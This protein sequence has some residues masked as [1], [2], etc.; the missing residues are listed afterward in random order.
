MHLPASIAKAEE[1][2]SSILTLSADPERLE[3]GVLIPSNS[4]TKTI[5]ITNEG[6]EKTSFTLSIVGYYQTSELDP[7]HT[8]ISEWLTFTGATE[9]TLAPQAST[10]ISLRVK[11][12]KDASAGG[13]YA[14]LLAGNPNSETI[15]LSTIS[16]IV[17]GSDLTYGG[18][19]SDHQ[20]QGFSFSPSINS[21]A[22]IKNSG[23]V[24]FE[25]KYKFTITPLFGSDP[26]Y[27]SEISRTILPSETSTIHQDWADA[28]IFGIFNA[29]QTITYV[30][31]DGEQVELTTARVAII[32]PIWL[33]IAIVVA[34]AAIILLIVFLKRHNKKSPHA[35]KNHNHKNHKKASWE[36]PQEG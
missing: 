36:Q 3:Y 20:I 26:I 22:T 16:A 4:Y 8:A 21:S 7:A 9:Y 33:I 35:H 5:S 32:C 27:D 28:P 15:T 24:D 6:A 14:S 11:I 29:T 31:S 23:N 34:L 2:E 12:P 1:A 19:V 18:E 25:A 17:S 30:N 13:Q 10:N